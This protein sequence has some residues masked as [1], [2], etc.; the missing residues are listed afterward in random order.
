MR[1]AKRAISQTEV[2]VEVGFEDFGTIE[3]WVDDR[4]ADR[5]GVEGLVVTTEA[6]DAGSLLTEVNACDFVTIV[7]TDDLCGDL[8]DLVIDCDR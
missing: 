6:N 8:D 5:Q 1:V 3:E 2:V 7:A 4:S